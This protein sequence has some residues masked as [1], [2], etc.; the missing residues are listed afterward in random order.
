[1]RGYYLLAFDIPRLDEITEEHDTLIVN[2]FGY[3][4]PGPRFPTHSQI[5]SIC[6]TYRPRV[7][8]HKGGYGWLDHSSVLQLY[9]YSP[10]QRVALI[11]VR[12]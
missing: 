1:M 2:G 3:D 11:T 5:V 6:D 12:T 9:A 10:A 7:F 4:E 8:G